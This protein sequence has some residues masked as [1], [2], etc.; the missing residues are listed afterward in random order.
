[1]SC[2]H[3]PGSEGSC[4]GQGRALQGRAPLLLP[5]SVRVHQL[6]IPQDWLMS[7][8]ASHE[9]V[10][11]LGELSEEQKVELEHSQRQLK[12]REWE[13]NQL[14]EKLSE[15]SSLVEE[16]DQALKA[17]AEELRY[18]LTSSEASQLPLCVPSSWWCS[19]LSPEQK[20]RV[21]VSGWSSAL[22]P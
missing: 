2:W 12:H 6:Q 1:M 11:C 7:Q 10:L 14:R 8:P 4:Q 17:A 19:G 3:G 22:N 13:V 16:K 9:A 20:T 15:M 18:T 21:R 5:A